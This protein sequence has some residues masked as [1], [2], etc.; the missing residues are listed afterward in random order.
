M[1]LVSSIN[2]RTKLRYAEG[3]GPCMQ[4]R[5]SPQ[6]YGGWGTQSLR[7]TFTFAESPSSIMMQ[8]QGHPVFSD[9]CCLTNSNWLTQQRGLLL[10]PHLCVAPWTICTLYCFG[11][12]CSIAIQDHCIRINVLSYI[13]RRIH[14]G[15]AF[16]M[17]LFIRIPD[18]CFVL[19]CR[20][21]Q[22]VT[23]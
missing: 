22:V 23:S 4:P 11:G 3:G 10:S 6:I 15:S 8:H 9:I 1:L 14:P 12:I 7:H 21:I 18:H 5:L 19:P 16:I 2:L 13:S 20:H 17:L